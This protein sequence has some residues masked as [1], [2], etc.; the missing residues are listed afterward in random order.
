MA[1]PSK[2]KTELQAKRDAAATEKAARVAVGDRVGA[3]AAE[4]AR[5]TALNMA[6]VF[7]DT[8]T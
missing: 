8:L 4:A 7:H 5:Q 6:A 3:A 1:L 2:A